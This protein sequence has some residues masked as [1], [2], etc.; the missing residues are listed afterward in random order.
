MSGFDFKYKLFSTD[1]GLNGQ[2]FR[3]INLSNGSIDRFRVLKYHLRL[4]NGMSFL[5]RFLFTGLSYLTKK[6]DRVKLKRLENLKV[7]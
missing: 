2:Y 7:S 4:P 5:Y 6:Y 1:W 3:F